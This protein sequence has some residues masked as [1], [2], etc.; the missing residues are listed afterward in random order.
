VSGQ[1]KPRGQLQ[2]GAGDGKRVENAGSPS[3]VA[4]LAEFSWRPDSRR[5][6][7]P[8][9]VVALHHFAD[10]GNRIIGG[11]VPVTPS[12]LPHHFSETR[13]SSDGSEQAHHRRIAA[14]QCNAEV[15]DNLADGFIGCTGIIFLHIGC[16]VS[17]G[18]FP[19]DWIASALQDAAFR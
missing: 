10:L 3:E 18:Y 4:E 14:S 16:V 12:F 7:G 11:S 2:A 5:S 6:P 17:H 13:A 1:T 19:F 8:W 15:L 9:N